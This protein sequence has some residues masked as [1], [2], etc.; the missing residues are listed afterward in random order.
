MALNDT[1][2]SIERF[3]SITVIDDQGNNVMTL[4]MAEFIEAITAQVNQNITIDGTGSP[5]GVV[6]AQ[7]RKT[8]LDTAAA[9]GSNFYVKKTGSGN[10]GWQLV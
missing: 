1:I 9:A 6:T 4:R 10:T 3:T 7:P 8:Y 2:S 5:E